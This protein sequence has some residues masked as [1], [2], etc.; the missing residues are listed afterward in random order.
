ML[1]AIQGPK[2]QKDKRDDDN[3][4]NEWSIILFKL[5]LSHIF[6]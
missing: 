3:W 1:I 2:Y 5:H 6:I 4:G